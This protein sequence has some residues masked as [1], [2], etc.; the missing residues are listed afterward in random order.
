MLQSV[1]INEGIFYL[2]M[3]VGLTV[4]MRRRPVRMPLHTKAPL[5]DLKVI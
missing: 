1:F 2:L 5:T 3:V 4:D